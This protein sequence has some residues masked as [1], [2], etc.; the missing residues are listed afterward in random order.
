MIGYL[1]SK[2]F[3]QHFNIL[4]SSSTYRPTVGPFT[5]KLM[6]RGR[7][8]SPER[9]TPLP[10]ARLSKVLRQLKGFKTDTELDLYPEMFSPLTDVWQISMLFFQTLCRVGRHYRGRNREGKF[11]FCHKKSF[12]TIT[13]TLR[14]RWEY[15]LCYYWSKPNISWFGNFKIKAFISFNLYSEQFL[16]KRSYY[17]VS[18]ALF[19]VILQ[20]NQPTNATQSI[21]FNHKETWRMLWLI[22]PWHQQFFP[23]QLV[24]PLSSSCISSTALC[25][26]RAICRRLGGGSNWTDIRHASRWRLT[27][28]KLTRLSY[29][30]QG[31]AWWGNS[32]QPEWT[33]TFCSLLYTPGF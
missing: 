25:C 20:L 5:I 32:R 12:L 8:L 16:S 7:E 29:I 14:L 6:Q 13:A 27:A 24:P 10:S 11:L 1:W 31:L 3:F 22:F 2:S 17:R 28:I 33:H 26:C 21:N 19:A 15:F 30:S 9:E 4:R 23:P 18:R